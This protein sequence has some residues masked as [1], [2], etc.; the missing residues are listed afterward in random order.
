MPTALNEWSQKYCHGHHTWLAGA[1]VISSSLSTMCHQKC[2][3]SHLSKNS[4]LSLY[5]SIL[6]IWCKRG[7]A[8][9]CACQYQFL[10]PLH[11]QC[12]QFRGLY[13]E[14]YLTL[15][16]WSNAPI[17]SGSKQSKRLMAT[18]YPLSQTAAGTCLHASHLSTK[19][20]FL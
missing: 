12:D 10:R 5:F 7:T 4:F 6:A 20:N 8:D 1:A 2:C 13:P 19:F 14:Q 17:I 18:L 11:S 16:S 15:H 9:R 3:K